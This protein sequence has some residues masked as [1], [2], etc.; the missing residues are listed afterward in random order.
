MKQIKLNRG[1]FAMVDDRDYAR[2]KKIHWWVHFGRN[3]LYAIGKSYGRNGKTL[4]MHRMINKT[5]DGFETDH[6]DGN[7]LNN[8]RH[9]L[10]TSTGN[11]N[12][13]NKGKYK[14]NTSGFKGVSKNYTKYH[15]ILKTGE[16][17][18][19]YYYCWEAAI[20]FL[21]KKYHLGKFPFTNKGKKLAAK[22]YNDMAHYFH[23]EFAK[24][25]KV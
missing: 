19:T 2:M 4:Y 5:P 15:R 16:E 24:L 13:H 22:R 10:R 20:W 18:I 25:N 12:N 11:Q 3:T 7:G 14:N 8:Q 17:K 6:K 23:G 9:N 1:K 21:G